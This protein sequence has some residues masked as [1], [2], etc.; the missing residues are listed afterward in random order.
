M[1]PWSVEARVAL[2]WRLEA[3][4]EIEP[5]GAAGLRRRAR[6]LSWNEATKC[7]ERRLRYPE[8]LS[9]ARHYGRPNRTSVA[10]GGRGP[11]APVMSIFVLRLGD[12]ETVRQW[13]LKF[14]Q[15]FADQIGREFIP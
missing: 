1:R 7:S 6:P 15:Q 5:V 13:A 4:L 14:G 8:R 3:P 12:D 9:P 11:L 10:H 2:C